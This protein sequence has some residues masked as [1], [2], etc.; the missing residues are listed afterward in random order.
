[1]EYL[2]FWVSHDGFKPIKKDISL[3]KYG[4]TYFPKRSTKVIRCNKL[5][6]Q[7]VAKVVT[8]F[9]ALNYNNVY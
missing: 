8:Y 7:Y 1:M 2:C 3:N 5:L 6:P 9:S 4:A